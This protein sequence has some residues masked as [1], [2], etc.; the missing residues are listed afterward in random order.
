MG[1]PAGWMYKLTGRAAMRSPGAPSHRREIER[2]FWEQI[3][4]GITSEK[5]AEVVGVSQAVGTRRFRHN[6]GMP[7]FMSKPLIREV[8]VVRGARRD[9][10]TFVSR[11]RST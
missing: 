5:A 6:G 10:V 7:L 11:R 4:T 1:R 8:L 3:A 2:R 9:W